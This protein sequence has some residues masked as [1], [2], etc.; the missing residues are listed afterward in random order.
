MTRR[1][2]THHARGTGQEGA[3][4]KTSPVEPCPSSP[5]KSIQYHVWK[6]RARQKSGAPR[7]ARGFVRLSRFLS[8]TSGVSSPER[9]RP[10][11]MLLLCTKSLD[12]CSQPE[13]PPLRRNHVCQ[14]ANVCAI[15]A[16]DAD[17]ATLQCWGLDAPHGASQ[18][19]GI[20][21]CVRTRPLAARLVRSERTDLRYRLSS[22]IIGK[23][24]F[25]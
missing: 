7:A 17:R 22:S 1:A 23:A 9:A 24:A 5:S 3:C 2:R 21:N 4:L 20:V 6:W 11:T 18:A 12:A 10:N 14:P 13:R 15:S 19:L 8:S 25:A 16:A